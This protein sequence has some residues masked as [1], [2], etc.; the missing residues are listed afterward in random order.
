MRR[1]I[2]SDILDHVERLRQISD[3]ASQ[4]WAIEKALDA[5]TQHWAEFIMAMEHE[6]EAGCRVVAAAGLAEAAA[7]LD[8]HVA[9]CQAMLASQY[10]GSYQRQLEQLLEQLN[11][12]QVGALE[13][14]ACN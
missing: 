5:I 1:L 3:K 2:E 9:Q 13:A 11:E 7:A 10:A 8:E 4:E 14:A 6:E 12:R